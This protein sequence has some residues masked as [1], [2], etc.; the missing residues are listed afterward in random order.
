[1]NQSDVKPLQ[2]IQPEGPN[3][4]VNGHHVEWQKWNFRIKLTPRKGLVIYSVAY[5]DGIQGQKSVA[6][7]RMMYP[8]KTFGICGSYGK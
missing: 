2:I 5:D 6:Q 8:D 3:F 4:H 1:V 7:I